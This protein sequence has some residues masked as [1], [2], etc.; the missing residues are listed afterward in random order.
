MEG[1]YVAGAP[2]GKDLDLGAFGRGWTAYWRSGRVRRR[3]FGGLICS[4]GTAAGAGMNRVVCDRLM[5]RG[6][7]GWLQ[8]DWVGSGGGATGSHQ[9]SSRFLWG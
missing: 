2:A 1:V 6:L 8:E 7:L 9:G 5:H 3:P 4:S